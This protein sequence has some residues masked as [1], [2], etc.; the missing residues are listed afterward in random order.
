MK[1][2]YPNHR[3][4]FEML[5]EIH[6]VD[7]PLPY[8]TL[9]DDCS[10]FC[11]VSC[12][13]GFAN[14]VSA[15]RQSLLSN[16]DWQTASRSTSS[17]DKY[18]ETTPFSTASISSSSSGSSVEEDDPEVRVSWEEND[19]GVRSLNSSDWSVCEESE[20]SRSSLEI[21]TSTL[22]FISEFFSTSSSRERSTTLIGG[23][24]WM[25]GKFPGVEAGRPDDE[26]AMLSLFAEV[27]STSEWMK[28]L[29]HGR[30]KSTL[31]SSDPSSVETL[32]SDRPNEGRWA[33][34]SDHTTEK[35]INQVRRKHFLYFASVV[36]F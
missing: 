25:S 36:V 14:S 26:D 29:L 12:W 18:D 11:C 6:V 23:S 22:D 10:S 24:L 20:I 16:V 32:C 13:N 27:Y 34:D 21:Q 5:K 1:I 35:N 17:K 9:G 3:H 28:R 33:L 2:K 31:P 30:L 19:S 8:V 4:K 7:L 15:R